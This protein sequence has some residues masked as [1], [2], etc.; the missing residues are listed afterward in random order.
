MEK[1]A[2]ARE[3]QEGRQPCGRSGPGYLLPPVERPTGGM[4]GHMQ[5]LNRDAD[6]LRQGTCLVRGEDPLRSDSRLRS[7]AWFLLWRHGGDGRAGTLRWSVKG[8]MDLGFSTR[9]KGLL[10]SAWVGRAIKQKVARQVAR[11]MKA[12]GARQ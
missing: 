2:L 1:G 10:W 11:E 4:H 7:R 9:G 6:D 5:D 8:A 3:S 12:G